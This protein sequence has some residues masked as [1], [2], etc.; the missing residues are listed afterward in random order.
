MSEGLTDEHR[1]KIEAAQQTAGGCVGAAGCFALGIAGLMTV[2]GILIVILTGGDGGVVL[3]VAAVIAL[4]LIA[5][6]GYVWLW[7]K[8]R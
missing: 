6:L 1:A 4:T 8:N 2:S 3:A 5:A 7:A